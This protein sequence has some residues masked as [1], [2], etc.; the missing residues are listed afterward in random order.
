MPS[1]WLSRR[2][3]CRK[4]EYVR[5]VGPPPLKDFPAPLPLGFYADAA[6]AAADAGGEEVEGLHGEPGIL[7][8]VY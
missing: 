6:S 3:I 4:L 1:T 5:P 2:K 7:H 8:T